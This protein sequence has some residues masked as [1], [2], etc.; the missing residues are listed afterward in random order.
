MLAR[1]SQGKSVRL[2]F[3]ECER[4]A[5]QA[6]APAAQPEPAKLGSSVEATAAVLNPLRLFLT[7]VPE[8]LVE[9]FLLNQLQAHHPELKDSINA[10]H[11]LLAATN[12]IP[13]VLLTP[14]ATRS[15]TLARAKLNPPICRQKRVKS[16]L[17][18]RWLRGDRP[19][20]PVI[21]I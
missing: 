1:T 8:A 17:A 18:T 9:G 15:R 13:E 19:T 11:G 21:S 6:I 4:I 7:T 20:T 16:F 3:L 5:K 12:A 14:T 2:Y 10:A